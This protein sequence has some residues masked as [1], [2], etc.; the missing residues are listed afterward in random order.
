MMGEETAPHSLEPQFRKLGLSTH[1]TRGVPT[2]ANE[3]T[4]CKKGDTLNAN[5]VNL[6]K[7][8]GKPL[9]TVSFP[10]LSALTLFP[11]WS[12]Y[13]VA[14]S[15][16]VLR[17]SKSS[18]ALVSRSLMVRCAVDPMLQLEPRVAGRFVAC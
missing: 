6:L 3:H 10:P 16:A 14:D 5:Q 1:L 11:D 8:F 9:A 4:V 15:D 18:P 13:G 7:L 12:L 2:L 17:S